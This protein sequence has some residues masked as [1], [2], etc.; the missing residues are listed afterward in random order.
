MPVK[1]YVVVI[2]VILQGAIFRVAKF[3]CVLPAYRFAVLSLQPLSVLQTP[4][5]SRE[6]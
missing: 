3:W 2:P 1:H 6:K 5:P 4:S